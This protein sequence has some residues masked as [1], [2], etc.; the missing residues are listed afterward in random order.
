M[1]KSIIFVFVILVLLSFTKFY[2][3][4]QLQNGGTIYN[5]T[6]DT[7]YLEE[8]NVKVNG[9][10][11]LTDLTAT[12]NVHFELPHAFLSKRDTAGYNQ[13]VESTYYTK[14]TGLST[15]ENHEFTILAGDTV[16]Y[17]GHDTAHINIFIEL[18]ATTS[19]VNDDIWVRVRNTR[20]G[21]LA[22]AMQTSRGTSNYQQWTITAYDSECVPND[23][24]V[25]EVTNKTNGNDLTVY[26]IT[27]EFLT[28]HFE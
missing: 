8:A 24:Y 12:G 21:F 28:K 14:F 25:I 18:N 11:V 27:Q 4:I 9:N 1:K 16:E 3:I 17:A 19:G 6:A 15:I 5:T 10:T 13:A 26:S 7:L 23:K 2:D 22:Y 20:S